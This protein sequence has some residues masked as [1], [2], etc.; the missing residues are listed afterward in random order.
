MNEKKNYN[1]HNF[2]NFIEDGF[3]ASRVKKNIIQA[4]STKPQTYKYANLKPVKPQKPMGAR[5]KRFVLFVIRTFIF[6]AALLFAIALYVM[7]NE[8]IVYHQYGTAF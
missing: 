2:N 6:F 7:L 1:T 8:F 3:D 5:Q 4:H